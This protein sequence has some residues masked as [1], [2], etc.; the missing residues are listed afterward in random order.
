MD[1]NFKYSHKE[2]IKFF[3]KACQGLFLVG[4]FINNPLN[5][6]ISDHSLNTFEEVKVFSPEE[7]LPDG[8]D[9]SISVNPYTGE[10][11]PARKGTVAATLNN[12]ALLNK[13]LSESS[14][15]KNLS[16]INPIMEAISSLAGSLKVI[17]MFDLFTIEEWIGSDQQPGRIL[18]AVLY[19]QKYPT[20]ITPEICQ[21]LENIKTSTKSNLLA[22]EIQKAL[23]KI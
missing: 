2:L 7:I 19:L 18:A 14:S 20:E 16:K 6:E 3:N 9:N 4:I 17:G 23:H 21:R 22:E 1:L 11:G 15:E 8:V 10:S 13:I 5:A 12:I